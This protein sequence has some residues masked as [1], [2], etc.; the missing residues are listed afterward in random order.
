MHRVSARVSALV[1]DSVVAA[2]GHSVSAR[3]TCRPEPFAMRGVGGLA[4][5]EPNSPRD[6]ALLI[7]GDGRVGTS[8]LGAL[9]FCSLTFSSQPCALGVG[10]ELEPRVHADNCRDSL[11]PARSRTWDALVLPV[12]VASAGVLNASSCVMEVAA[13]PHGARVCSPGPRR[14][15]AGPYGR[16]S[17]GRERL[18]RRARPARSFS[19]S[20]TAGPSSRCSW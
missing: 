17:R 3:A 4:S 7:P 5:C 2:V 1:T 20:P 9:Q 19:G 8:A 11:E 16:Q 14:R 10:L 18:G 13:A 6:S 15:R 12:P